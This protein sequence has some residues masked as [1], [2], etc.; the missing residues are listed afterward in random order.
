MPA[1]ADVAALTAAVGRDPAA[2]VAI[3]HRLGAHRERR[4]RRSCCSGWSAKPP[5]SSVRK[6]AKRALYRLQQRGVAVASAE[7]D[8]RRAG[9]DAAGAAIEGY[10]SPVDGRGDQLVWLVRSRSPAAS[11]TCSR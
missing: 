11:R 6:E 2:D 8:T 3:A 1:D 10:V 5:T 7:P 9:A 4:E